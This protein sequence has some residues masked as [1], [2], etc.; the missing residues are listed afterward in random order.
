MDDTSDELSLPAGVRDVLPRFRVHVRVL[1]ALRARLASVPDA[2]LLGCLS[3]RCVVG[4]ADLPPTL[5]ADAVLSLHAHPVAPRTLL[6]V[7][8][9]ESTDVPSA[10]RKGTLR[11]RRSKQSGSHSHAPT[12]APAVLLRG[13]VALASRAGEALSLVLALEAPSFALWCTN[14]ASRLP[15]T[16]LPLVAD[17]PLA[18]ALAAGTPVHDTETTGLLSRAGGRVVAPVRAED[19]PTDPAGC[20]ALGD[21]RTARAAAAAFV[22]RAASRRNARLQRRPRAAREHALSLDF[23]LAHY[24]ASRG[25]PPTLY[26]CA[27]RIETGSETYVASICVDTRAIAHDVDTLFADF[28]AASNIAGTDALLQNSTAG[29]LSRVF[30]QV[31]AL[32]AQLDAHTATPDTHG[33]SR[34]SSTALSYAEGSDNIIERDA[35]PGHHSPTDGNTDNWVDLDNLPRAQEINFDAEDLEPIGAFQ[36]TDAPIG[37][38]DLKTSTEDSR[39]WRRIQVLARKYLGSDFLESTP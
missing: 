15:P 29:S 19:M 10:L 7:V 5:Y 4:D 11:W 6:P 9:C 27:A 14:A 32:R 36:D 3:A 39:H 28:D 16:S 26:R 38:D 18:L 33:E 35:P 20:W 21:A 2:E 25:G 34:P 37:A 8:K 24:S 30:D 12:T 1:S 31:D 22:L 13:A 17:N 23:L